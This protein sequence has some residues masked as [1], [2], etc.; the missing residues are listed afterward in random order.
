[1]KPARSH[2]GNA[3]QTNS[4]DVVTAPTQMRASPP[5]HHAAST[6][7]R[8][9]APSTRPPTYQP[10][11]TSESES[12]HTTGTPSSAARTEA[13][14]SSTVVITVC[15][16]RIAQLTPPAQGRRPVS[17]SAIGGGAGRGDE[18]AV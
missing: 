12:T 6:A 8:V 5:S 17:R 2:S 11:K 9:R 3:S 14:T 10:A 4:S 15:P 7:S 18:D 13:M 16:R 1:M